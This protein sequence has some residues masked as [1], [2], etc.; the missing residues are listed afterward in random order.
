MTSSEP[1]PDIG[2][3]RIRLG[4]VGGGHGAF[5]GA[6]HR[7][8]ARLDDEF[9][10]V[11][12]ALSSDALRARA[13][14]SDL[15][16]TTDRSYASYREMARAEAAREDG[17]EAV[18]IVTPNHLHA[19]IAREFLEAG[20]HVICEKPMAVSVA[21]AEGLVD[22]V[23]RTGRL[24]VLT[25]NYTG[26]AMV[27]QARGMI[28]RGAIGTIRLIHVEYL[29]DWLSEKLEDSGLR[30]A[31]WRTD[32]ARSGAGGCIGDI[33]S[34]AYN[35]VCFV[36]GL[37][38][39]ALCA[40]LTTFVEGRRLDDNTQVMMRFKGGA[41]GLLWASQVALGNDNGLK[42]RVYG[43]KGAIEWHQ[44]TPNTLCY[45]PLGSPKQLISR[46]ASGTED[47]A[48]L[49]S[50]TPAG[51][52]EGY[53]EGFANIYR[54][55]AAAIRAAREGCPPPA[56][57]MYPTVEDGCDG[58]RFIAAAIESSNAGGIWKKV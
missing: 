5:I 49:M 13:S 52:P 39:Q 19:E 56:W 7:I 29:Q 21:E 51:H 45:S 27:R 20:I 11:A 24:F 53:V 17:I 40:E 2:A 33:G 4:M 35:L 46:N 28:A 26:Y 3:P 10:L 54:Q 36:S 32:P 6:I 48:A 1:K 23:E 44:E 9:E 30:Q 15:R 14:A 41:R 25:H 12:G 57:V 16:I 42:L 58:M 37:E 50:R 38:L 43:D 31:E 22:L 8:A 47:I 55:A 34:H 18:S